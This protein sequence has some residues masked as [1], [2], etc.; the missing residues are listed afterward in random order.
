MHFWTLI[1]ATSYMSHFSVS[2]VSSR[3]PGWVT[4][5]KNDSAVP[6]Y[7]KL[8]FDLDT[9]NEPQGGGGEGHFI[10]FSFTLGTGR[11][12]CQYTNIKLQE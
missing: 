11:I 1:F 2:D 7:R 6:F 12:D 5:A 10:P 8:Y 9:H 3:H 4:L